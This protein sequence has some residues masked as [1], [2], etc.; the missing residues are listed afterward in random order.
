[1]SGFSGRDCEIEIAGVGPAAGTATVPGDKKDGLQSRSVSRNASEI[2][3]TTD[4][5]EGWRKLLPQP[6]IRSVDLSFSGVMK[7][8][9]FRASSGPL[10]RHGQHRSHT[11]TKIVWPMTG[12]RI[13]RE[14]TSKKPASFSFSRSKHTA[15]HS[16]AVTFSATFL[17]PAVKS[18]RYVREPTRCLPSVSSWT[19]PSTGRSISVSPGRRLSRWSSAGRTGCQCGSASTSLR[20]VDHAWV[21]YCG[22]YPHVEGLDRDEVIEAVMADPIT[23]ERCSLD[24]VLETLSPEAARQIEANEDDEGGEDKDPLSET[25][26]AI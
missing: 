7:V 8:G 5:D 1:M 11:M 9:E 17:S 18:H 16:G 13:Q 2:D 4:D 20:I 23:Y 6:G 14:I 10:Q 25:A 26:G 3:V 22:L 12:A 24:L 15:E 21:L 19:F